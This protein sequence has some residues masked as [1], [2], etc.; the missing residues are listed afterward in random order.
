MHKI[1]LVIT[2]ILASFYAHGQVYLGP[3]GGYNFSSVFFS[4]DI[5]VPVDMSQSTILGLAFS[6]IPE[7]KKPGILV[8]ANYLDNGFVE[9]QGDTGRV[10]YSQKG[11]NMQFLSH[12]YLQFGKIRPFVNMGPGVGY[13]SDIS[14][15]G[16]SNLLPPFTHH[17]VKMFY[18]ELTGGGG[19]TYSSKIGD[20]SLF[21]YYSLSTLKVYRHVSWD[22]NPFAIRAGISY[23]I[24]LSRRAKPSGVDPL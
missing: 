8:L 23:Q 20:F 7:N 6:Y 22:S 12:L 15:E 13:Y 19:I 17:W 18:L 9:I 11:L 5:S 16:N 3:Q 10:N 21:S 1:I 14:S 2:C 24:P 4:G